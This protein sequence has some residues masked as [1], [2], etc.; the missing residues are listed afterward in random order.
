[1]EFKAKQTQ[2]LKENIRIEM[3][4]RLEVGQYPGVGEVKINVS[5]SCEGTGEGAGLGL[6]ATNDTGTTLQAWSITRD[7]MDSPVVAD[8]EAV[9]MALL[10]AQQNGWRN[11]EIQ[12]DIW[13]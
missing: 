13:F 7:R 4:E 2:K 1:M 3:G 6:I 8:V 11:I 5:F 12:V 10:V 9:C